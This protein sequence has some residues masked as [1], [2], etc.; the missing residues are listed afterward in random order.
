MN[1]AVT[2]QYPLKLVVQKFFHRTDLFRPRVPRNAA[3]RRQRVSSGRAGQMIA[4]EQKLVAIKED[5]VSASV[6]RCWDHEQIAVELNRIDAADDAF[7]VVTR[8]AVVGVHDS[9]A[10]ESFAKQLVIG[11]VVLM[12]QQHLTDAAHRVDAFDQ[13]CGETRRVDQQVAAFVLR[14]DNQVTPGAERIFRSETAEV[15]VVSDLSRESVDADMRIVLFGG[16][17][18]PGWTSDEGH[19]CLACFVAGF[20]LVMDAAL[21]AVIAKDSRREL[22]ASVAVDAGG[23]YKEITR[24]IL[25]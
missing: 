17:D 2:G 24:Y 15:N 23:I 7:D 14:A 1:L 21:I 9:L 13:L 22:T 12:R 3:K 6:T 8:R 4:R 25:R 16:T 10:A 18:R 20:R 5:H 11:D 19:H